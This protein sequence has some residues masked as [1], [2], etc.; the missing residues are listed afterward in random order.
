MR[1]R[2]G[3]EKLAL[4]IDT[5]LPLPP[6]RL[7]THPIWFCTCVP[8]VPIS[9]QIKIK[10]LARYLSLLLLLLRTTF[11]FY[12]FFFFF[13]LSFFLSFVFFF[14]LISFLSLLFLHLLL[15]HPLITFDSLHLLLL[16][17]DAAAVVVDRWFG[18]YGC[19]HCPCCQWSFGS[20]AV[21]CFL[22]VWRLCKKC[23][24]GIWARGR[25]E[26]ISSRR[27]DAQFRLVSFRR[28]IAHRRGPLGWER[29]R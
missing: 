12:F 6:P 29:E 16:P 13:F 8:S 24:A 5:S 14:G 2:P 27:R 17:V 25:D 3:D 23:V 26:P 10:K 19:H 9:G 18:S 1:T 4:G 22:L 28:T 11:W 21:L 20:Y 7:L 15:Y